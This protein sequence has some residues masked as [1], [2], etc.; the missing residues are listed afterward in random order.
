MIEKTCSGITRKGRRGRRRAPRYQ[1]VEAP[2]PP[3]LHTPED[4]VLQRAH[5]LLFTGYAAC[6]LEERIR[7][8]RK[9]DEMVKELRK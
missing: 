5:N 9:Q 1:S 4:A 6:S 2:K 7:I 8:V 3:K